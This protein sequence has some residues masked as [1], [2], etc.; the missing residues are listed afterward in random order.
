MKG[1][2]DQDGRFGLLKTKPEDALWGTEGISWE[3]DEVE[4]SKEFIKRHKDEILEV[5]NCN[6]LY[7]LIKNKKE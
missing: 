4:I 1:I 2:I 3:V 5:I 7:L 6:N